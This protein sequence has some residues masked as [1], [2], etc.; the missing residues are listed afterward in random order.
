MELGTAVYV[1]YTPLLSIHVHSCVYT[2][3]HVTAC[4]R[5]ESINVHVSDEDRTENATLRQLQS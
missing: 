1:F 2:C 4:V 5:L 3:V